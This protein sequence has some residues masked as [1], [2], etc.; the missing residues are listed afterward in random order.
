MKQTILFVV[1]LAALCGAGQ[2]WAS[3]PLATAVPA[4]PPSVQQSRMKACAAQYHQ[5]KLAKSQYKSFMSQ[6]LKT[7]PATG[8]L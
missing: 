8:K 6:C 7:T 2:V 1:V 5:Q 4:Q 3:A